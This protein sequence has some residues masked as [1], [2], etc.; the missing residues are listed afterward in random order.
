MNEIGPI[1]TAG[2][3]ENQQLKEIAFSKSPEWHL[4]GYHLTIPQS[5][6]GVESGKDWQGVQ[7][8]QKVGSVQGQD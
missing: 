1:A 6:L 8:M 5:E 3:F 7:F 2:S 4:C